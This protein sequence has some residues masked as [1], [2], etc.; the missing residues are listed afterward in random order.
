MV[1]GAETKTEASRRNKYRR[2]DYTHEMRIRGHRRSRGN[3]Q[4]RCRGVQIRLTRKTVQPHAVPHDSRTPRRGMSNKQ[5]TEEG[6]NIS[7]FNQKPTEV[8][9]YQCFDGYGSY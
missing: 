1:T 4:L 3:V 9:R 2:I 7:S 5:C 6:Y 8:N